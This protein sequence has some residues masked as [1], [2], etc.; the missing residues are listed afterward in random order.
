MPPPE[1]V[2]LIVRVPVVALLVVFIVI[3]VDPG[4]ER[5]FDENVTLSPLPR[6]EA[7][8]VTDAVTVPLR[9]MVELPEF[10]LVTVREV[11]LALIV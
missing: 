10:P 4:A 11:G 7:E 1:A 5:L 3:R 8:N 6:P 2:T 9:V